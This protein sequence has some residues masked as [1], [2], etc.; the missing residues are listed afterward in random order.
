MPE[1]MIETDNNFEDRVLLTYQDG[2][3]SK[4]PHQIVKEMTL[5]IVLNGEKL[6][7]LVCSPHSFELLAR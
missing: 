5:T 1:Q 2:R 3:K 7:T 4:A 6:T